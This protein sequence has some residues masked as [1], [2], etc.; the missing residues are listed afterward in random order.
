MELSTRAEVLL[1]ALIERYISDG[2]PVGSRTLA[3]QAGLELSPAT[4]RNI[5]AD[6]E[7]LGL[8]CSLHTSSGR[9]PTDLG[10]RVFVDTLLKVRP[11]AV[12]ELYRLE[13]ELT[14]EQDP[15]QLVEVASGLLSQVTRY[16][17]LVMVPKCE[18]VCFRQ[19]EFLNLSANRVLVILVTQ[20]GRVH[21]RILHTQ[22]PYSPAELTEASNY[23]N[24]TYAAMP[25]AT[26]RH[27]LLHGMQQDGEDMQQALRTAVEMAQQVFCDRQE[28]DSELVVSGESNLLN[29]PELGDIDKLRRL[30]SAF[31]AKRDLLQLLDQSLRAEGVK[32]YIGRESG[33][34][35]LE[36]CSV[37]AA[38]Y[39]VDGEVVGTLGVIGPMRMPYEQVIA[40]VDIT[41]RLLGGALSAEGRGPPPDARGQRSA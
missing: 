30:F 33:Y 25:L 18:Q 24:R 32:I 21:N 36:E 11:V 15:Q 26:V 28:K 38:S 17:G 41:A 14:G 29:I 40:V 12:T 7:D 16:T 22:R 1:K 4:V 39:Q 20:D 34:Q 37:V 10:Y 19:I 35:A 13:H 2:Q 27:E 31:N 8:I 23:F 9:M 6:L 3:M 5:M